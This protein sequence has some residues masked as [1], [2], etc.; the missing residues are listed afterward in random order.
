M[1]G[2]IH[3]LPIYNICALRGLWTHPGNVNLKTVDKSCG[4]VLI[5]P[6]IGYVLPLYIAQCL[7]P[8]ISGSQRVAVYRAVW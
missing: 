8:S 5:F 2:S 6:P 4:I 7:P 3:K 1:L